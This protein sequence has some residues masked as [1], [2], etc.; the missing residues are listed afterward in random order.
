MLGLLLTKLILILEQK[1]NY[2]MKIVQIILIQFFVLSGL[3]QSSSRLLHVKLVNPDINELHEYYLTNSLD[4]LIQL[5]LG[6]DELFID[7]LQINCED[8]RSIL[9]FEKKLRKESCSVEIDVGESILSIVVI[10]INFRYQ[11]FEFDNVT[12]GKVL[13]LMGADWKR[14][15]LKKS[16][17]DAIMNW[18]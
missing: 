10:D 11:I 17:L 13:K 2:N 18:L 8:L 5:E 7:T 14:S 16:E 12:Y 9:T 1:L 15:T 3:S 6:E 4:G